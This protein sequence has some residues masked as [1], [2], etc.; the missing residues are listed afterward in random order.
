LIFDNCAGLTTSKYDAHELKVGGKKTCKAWN[1]SNVFKHTDV[2]G[3]SIQDKKE[4]SKKQKGSIS[5]MLTM[6]GQSLSRKRKEREARKPFCPL[7]YVK[8]SRRM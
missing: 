6:K 8:V 1:N 3:I 4:K 7:M 2:C 5:N